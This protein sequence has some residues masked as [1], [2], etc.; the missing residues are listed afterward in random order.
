MIG[1]TTAGK[2]FWALWQ[3]KAVMED[4]GHVIYIH[5]EEPNPAGTISR[6]L[7]MGADREM[8]RKQFHWPE[9]RPWTRGEMEREVER[10]SDPP[11]LAVLDGI[12]AACGDHGWDV[13]VA[14]SVGAYRSMFVH[15]LTSVDCAVLSLGHPVK[16]PGRQTESYSYG[17]A[18]WLNDVDGVSYRLKASKDH[19]IAKKK[20]G[21]SALY[22][23]KDR[24]GDVNEW[25]VLQDSGDMPWYYKGSFWVDDTEDGIFGVQ[26]LK[27]TIP[28]IDAE[29]QQDGLDVLG[30]KILAF[31]RDGRP[32]FASQ[33]KLGGADA[34]RRHQVPPE[35]PGTGT[36][37]AR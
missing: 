21:S 6:L 1:L 14:S 32:S 30:Q 17:A 31:L 12:N 3:A 24:Y 27:V 25:G 18:G 37:A 20:E 22:S 11:A 10:L 35:R 34:G 4:G 26:H 33:N 16:A 7:H 36:G 19:P 29:E 15:P 8:I 2:T 5:F 13:S 9:N 28:S 23:V